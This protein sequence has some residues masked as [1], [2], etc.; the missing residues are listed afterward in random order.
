MASRTALEAAYLLASRR[1]HSHLSAEAETICISARCTPTPAVLDGLVR[2]PA[3][4]EA[5]SRRGR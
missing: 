1:K 4:L 3:H 5:A 2:P